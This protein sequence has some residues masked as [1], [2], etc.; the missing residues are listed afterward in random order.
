MISGLINIIRESE[1]RGE[2]TSSLADISIAQNKRLIH[3]YKFISKE[4]DIE[5]SGCR[6]SKVT[7]LLEADGYWLKSI[8]YIVK[9]KKNTVFIITISVDSQKPE[10]QLIVANSIINSLII[11]KYE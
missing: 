9:T 5:I 3:G 8:Q 2:S 7:Q 1:K 11:N 6:G 4:N 10:R